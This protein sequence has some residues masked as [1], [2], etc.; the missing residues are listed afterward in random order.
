ML[1]SSRQILHDKTAILNDGH[2]KN[3]QKLG[4]SVQ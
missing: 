3:P 1:L 4:L 2:Q